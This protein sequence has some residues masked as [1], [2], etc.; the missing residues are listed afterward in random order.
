MGLL[1]PLA[2]HGVVC[3]S[4]KPAVWFLETSVSWIMRLGGV[5][6]DDDANKSAMDELHWCSGLCEDL[7][8]HWSTRARNHRSASRLS[9]TPVRKI[10]L[11]A[12][13]IDML[14][15]DQTLSEA[16]MA[17]H[18]NMHTRYPVTEES[19][20]PQRIVGYVNFKDIVANMRFDSQSTSFRN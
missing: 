19:G 9:T 6:G 16:L 8:T 7:S 1:N 4:V 11:P 10:A 3:V 15:A 13:H 18:L 12:E 20:N 17:A 14:V 2:D 5:N